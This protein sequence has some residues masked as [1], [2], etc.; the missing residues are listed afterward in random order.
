MESSLY[1]R[2]RKFLDVS[3]ATIEPQSLRPAHYVP[4]LDGV[5]ALAVVPVISL[6]LGH[7][8]E[9]WKAVFSGGFLGVDLFFVLSGYLITS[10]LIREF[11]K[12]GTIRLSKF[13][14]RRALRL[15][16]AIIALVMAHFV[17]A[18][19]SNM[20]MDTEIRT[21][22]SILFY[23][24]N[25]QIAYG[26]VFA[27]DLGHMWSL[28][29]EEQFYLVWPVLL[30]LLGPLINRPRVLAWVVAGTICL[31]I[32]WRAWLWSER[33]GDWYWLTLYPRTDLRADS[34]LMGALFAIIVLPERAIKRWLPLVGSLGLLAVLIA[35]VFITAKNASF[36]FYGGLTLFAFA[37]G[38]VIFSVAKLEGWWSILFDN[39]L[40]RGIGRVSYGLYIWHMPIFAATARYT[41]SYPLV[42][43]ITIALSALLLVTL[44][45]WFCI[46]KP[47]LRLKP[48]FD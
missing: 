18:Y 6:H 48:R 46:E 29:V 40:A 4:G 19:F 5:R 43:Q 16:P 30:I 34:L 23:Y 44:F 41:Q 13:Y 22:S 47:F 12:R 7:Y 2:L 17:Y 42:L 38:L 25:F 10:I 31:V 15:F 45:S 11:G 37:S 21:L 24:S 39:I 9:N 32:F 33:S 1:H 27:T 14:I 8:F 26:G 35:L 20:P 3:T 28:A 36:L